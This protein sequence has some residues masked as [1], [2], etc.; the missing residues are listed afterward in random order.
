[1]TAGTFPLVQSSPCSSV[2]PYP[3]GW[4]MVKLS[5]LCDFIRGTEPGRDQYNRKGEGVTFIRVGNIAAGRQESVFT[6]ASN[7]VLCDRDD[8]LMSFDGSPGVVRRGFRGAISSGIRKVVPRDPQLDRDFLFYAL[9]TPVV[10][11]VVREH[12]S[13]VTIKHA[14]KAIPHLQVLLPPMVEQR[15]IAAHLRTL[16][17]ATEATEVVLAATRR[18][19]ASLMRHVF[20]Y[21]PVP[22]GE[23]DQ[24][25]LTT[26]QLGDL[27]DHWRIVRLEQIAD[28]SSGGTPDRSR[29]DYWGGSIPWIRT[30]EVNYRTISSAGEHITDLGLAQSSARVIQ[31][32]AILMAMYGQGVTR[33]RVAM[34]GIDAAINQACAAIEVKPTIDSRFLYHWLAYRYDSIRAMGHGANQKNL[35]AGM[36]RALQV[37]LPPIG[38]QRQIADSLEAVEAKLLVESKQRQA[39]EKLFDSLSHELLTGNRQIAELS[40]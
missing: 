1:M 34:L 4:R 5:E 36:I 14:S 11:Q 12:A 30:G 7:V 24:L 29:S 28:V 15:A 21:G 18:L 38:E 23:T 13:G 40:A 31:K 19:N 9:Q 33:G 8:V 39:L 37:P 35:N 20:T 17:Q 6:T 3:S 26:T 25:K 16:R 27:P 10:Q 2:T 22:P 32:G